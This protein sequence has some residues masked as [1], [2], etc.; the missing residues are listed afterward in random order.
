MEV[1]AN[2][3]NEEYNVFIKMTPYELNAKQKQYYAE[4]HTLQKELDLLLDELRAAA[5]FGQTSGS[6]SLSCAS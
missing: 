1:T 5:N 6:A 2:S 4:L 3:C